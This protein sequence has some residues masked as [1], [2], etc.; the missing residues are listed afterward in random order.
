MKTLYKSF[1]NLGPFLTL[2]SQVNFLPQKRPRNCSLDRMP[3]SWDIWKNGRW[4]WNVRWK[5]SGLSLLGL[6]LAARH[7]PP[8]IMS[9]AGVGCIF[10][11]QNKTKQNKTEMP[12]SK[13]LQTNLWVSLG[14]KL[15]QSHHF[16][17][18]PISAQSASTWLFGVWVW[19]RNYD[20]SFE[21]S[22]W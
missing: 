22:L 5:A 6:L 16:V 10:R 15:V 11:K 1:I 20:Q 19:S 4:T 13:D 18:K 7:L 3:W 21:G 17:L 14:Q 2:I 8:R 12:L 9:Q